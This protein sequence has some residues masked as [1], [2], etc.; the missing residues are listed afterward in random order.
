MSQANNNSTTASPRL[1]IVM[2]FF[3]NKVLTGK[4]IDSIVANTFT[5]WELIAVD[6]GS[7]DDTLSYLSKYENNPRITIVHR[8]IQPKGA[9][10]C[11]NMGLS[12]AQGEYIMF[13]DSDDYIT[14]TCLNT[15][16]EH[17]AR[18]HELD[19]MV[20]PSAVLID[21]T[22]Y[23][24]AP[25]DLYGY[26]VYDDDI[27]AFARRE[28]P[29]IVWSNIYRT[30][31]LRKAEIKWDTKLL[32]LQDADFNLQ[33]ITAGLRYDYAHTMPD[34]GYRTSYSI[35]SISK[36]ICS[37]EHSDSNIYA[38][39]KFFRTLRKHFGH[40]Y[41]LAAFQGVL[42]LYNTIFTNGIEK[43]LAFRMADCVYSFHRTFGRIFRLQIKSTLLLER[44]I[45]RKRARQI[46]MIPYLLP[47]IIRK[48]KARKRI[49][50]IK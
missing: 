37:K 4:M 45:P 32:S 21:D 40:K 19:F 50:P 3:N 26:N 18:N 30:N 31:S 16:V 8:D 17:I 10:T 29:F 11:R 42:N 2:P 33:A 7:D 39:E 14:P 25:K 48:K 46:P 20:F 35:N 28:L 27:K 1:T 41:D 47:F 5:E 49:T 34:Y 38:M 36:K 9:Q 13:V 15:R 24:D 6:D 44:L 12:L 22:I 43:K 23:T